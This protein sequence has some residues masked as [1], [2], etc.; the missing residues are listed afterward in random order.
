MRRK[1]LAGRTGPVASCLPMGRDWGTGDCGPDMQ[2]RDSESAH[3]LLELV[4]E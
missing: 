2:I 3:G 1:W 4:V